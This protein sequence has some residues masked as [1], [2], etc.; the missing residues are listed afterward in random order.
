MFIKSCKDDSR[1]LRITQETTFDIFQ[2]SA[3]YEGQPDNRFFWLTD[4]YKIEDFDERF[5]VGLCFRKN[6]IIRA[7]LFCVEEEIYNCEAD[8]KVKKN[9]EMIFKYIKDNYAFMYRN[10]EHSYDQRN[11]YS[12]IVITF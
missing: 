9:E 12:S 6:K 7:E 5:K 3:L 11:G 4:Y 2:M 1:S 10:I 8:K